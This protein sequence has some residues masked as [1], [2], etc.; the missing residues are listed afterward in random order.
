MKDIKIDKISIIAIIFL[1]ICLFSGNLL[2]G[3]ITDSPIEID[4]LEKLQAINNDHDGNFILTVNIDASE[5]STWNE[6]AGFNPIGSEDAG[7]YFIGTFDGNGYTISNLY[8]NRPTENNVGLFGTT[9]GA[10]ITNLQLTNADITGYDNVGIIAG[11]IEHSDISQCF[12]SGKVTSKNN[13]CGGLIGNARY[14][15]IEDSYANVTIDGDFVTGSLVGYMINSN[16]TNSYGINDGKSTNGLIGYS[17]EKEYTLVG[18]TITSS[19]YDSTVTGCTDTDAGT[20][21]STSEMQTIT[22][23]TDWDFDNTWKIEENAYP[24]LQQFIVI[25]KT[26]SD[27]DSTPITQTENESVNESVNESLNEDVNT[28]AIIE[29]ED[30]KSYI[31]LGSLIF[32]LTLGIIIKNKKGK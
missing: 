12:T 28:N 25:P 17:V 27:S 32:I 5:T 18:N 22:T 11:H 29:Q 31:L 13:A 6:G 15:N 16:V 4:T 14:L 30:I 21:K 9:T 10:T 7:E 1:G 3:N 20:P 24:T 2:L 26:S 8:I 19:Y 23:Y